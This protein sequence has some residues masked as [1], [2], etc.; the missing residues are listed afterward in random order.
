MH[1]QQRQNGYRH[2]SPSSGVYRIYHNADRVHAE[3][4]Q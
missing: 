1:E 4:E 3:E 2:R